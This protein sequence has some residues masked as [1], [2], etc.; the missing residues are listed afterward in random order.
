LYPS[1]KSTDEKSEQELLVQ[2]FP[3]LQLKVRELHARFVEIEFEKAERTRLRADLKNLE[4]Q[5]QRHQE[6]TSAQ[7]EQ[8]E[9]RL[10]ATP[11]VPG[12]NIDERIQQ[13]LP[14]CTACENKTTK[15]TENLSLTI[16]QLGDLWEKTNHNSHQATEL[17]G[18]VAVL[19]REL[20]EI[21]AMLN[22]F[23]QVP[24]SEEPQTIA[25]DD[26]RAIRKN[27]DEL[28]QFISSLS[29]K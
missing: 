12:L 25:E 23:Q 16:N 8:L 14:K 17:S 18:H 9:Q 3:D 29:R 11:E 27:L 24:K 1:S 4:Q 20:S 6:R 7:L 15:L 28:G 5:L 21:K 26:V 22:L 10:S 13:I 2:E 19:Q